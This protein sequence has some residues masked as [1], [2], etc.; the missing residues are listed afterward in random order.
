[1]I[2]R[3]RVTGVAA[4]ARFT[5]EVDANAHRDEFWASTAAGWGSPRLLSFDP[6]MLDLCFTQVPGRSLDWGDG[7]ELASRMVNAASL[8]RRYTWIHGDVHP[9]NVRVSGDIWF[10]CDWELARPGR[11]DEDLGSLLASA[12]LAHNRDIFSWAALSRVV[13]PVE[14]ALGAEVARGLVLGELDRQILREHDVEDHRRAEERAA[15]RARLA[16]R[17]GLSGAAGDPS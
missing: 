5:A 2:F 10:L 1:M 13:S 17:W 6:S 4:S 8:A 12:F 15:L 16:E 9:A 7:A 11:F 14:A 3:K